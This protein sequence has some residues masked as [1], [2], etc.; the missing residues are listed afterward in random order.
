VK[1]P[2]QIAPVR[3]FDRRV[4]ESPP[5]SGGIVATWAGD[6]NFLHS[7]ELERVSTPIGHLNCD[8]GPASAGTPALQYFFCHCKD[9]A[10]K[11][12]DY[13]KCCKYQNAAGAVNTCTCTLTA[14]AATTCNCAF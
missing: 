5:T 12:T 14:G 10:G 9:A 6:R 2:Q 11:P 8:G 1:L 3:R 4:G 7:R 13:Y